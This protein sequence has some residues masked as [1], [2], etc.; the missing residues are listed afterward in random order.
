M[1]SLLNMWCGYLSQYSIGIKQGFEDCVE[2]F[3]ITRVKS[4]NAYFV[5]PIPIH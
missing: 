5:I 4:I 2:K 3:G 1:F